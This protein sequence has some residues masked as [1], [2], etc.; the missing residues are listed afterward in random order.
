[1]ILTT[2][3]PVTII[4][5]ILIIIVVT[6]NVVT[7][8][9]WRTLTSRGHIFHPGSHFSTLTK[10]FRF[11]R[12]IWL[13]HPKTF[14]TWFFFSQCLRDP[15]KT[16]ILSRIEIKLNLNPV[17]CWRWWKVQKSL[18]IH[19][20]SLFTSNSFLQRSNIKNIYT[21]PFSHPQ[22]MAILPGRILFDLNFQILWH[23]NINTGCI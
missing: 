14:S 22:N 13:L 7:G 1:M 9:G 21:I 19:I 2:I 10:L 20:S 23:L 16:K 17:I 18:K 6:G 12:E 3:I 11:G 5:I 8:C 4:I 15:W